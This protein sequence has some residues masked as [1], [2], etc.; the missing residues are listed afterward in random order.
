MCLAV[1]ISALTVLMGAIPSEPDRLSGAEPGVDPEPPSELLE[2]PA[3][4]ATAPPLLFLSTDLLTIT[5]SQNLLAS[6]PLTLQQ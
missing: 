2:G 6:L 3:T 5:L 4:S 1:K